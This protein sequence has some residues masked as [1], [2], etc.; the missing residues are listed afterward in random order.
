[1]PREG[2]RPK[3]PGQ[4]QPLLCLLLPRSRS[5][6]LSQELWPEQALHR[7]RPGRMSQLREPGRGPRLRQ[8]P[9]SHLQMGTSNRT[10]SLVA[11]WAARG[12]G[13][14]TDN[15]VGSIAP[16][17][18]N[19]GEVTFMSPRVWSYRRAPREREFV[20]LVAMSLQGQ[21]ST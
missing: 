2:E 3:R 20:L 13:H 14:K 18:M 15:K 12:C 8:P 7:G 21:A 17:P 11:V 4:S 6:S 1:M 10:H 5:S 16:S 19:S 9:L